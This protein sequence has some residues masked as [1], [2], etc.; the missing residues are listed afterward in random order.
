MKQKDG[1][2]DIPTQEITVPLSFKIDGKNIVIESGNVG[3]SPV[4]APKNA[5]LQIARSGVVRTKIQNALPTRKFDR[6][7]TIDKG[8]QTPV[9]VGISSVK[10]SGGWM[11]LTFE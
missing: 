8:L 5:T 1:E 11:V 6:S 10:A 2:E 7:V 3:V 4:E 9:A